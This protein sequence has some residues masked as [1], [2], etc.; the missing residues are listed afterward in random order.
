MTFPRSFPLF[1]DSGKGTEIN[2]KI[3]SSA[4]GFVCLFGIKE[5]EI[6]LQHISDP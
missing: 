3:Y 2:H 6:S 1:F 5:E 4:F